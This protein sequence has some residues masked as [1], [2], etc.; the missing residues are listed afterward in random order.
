MSVAHTMPKNHIIVRTINIVHASKFDVY[1]ECVMCS[2]E[3]SY[4]PEEDDV[5][6]KCGCVHTIIKRKRIKAAIL[7][8]WAEEELQPSTQRGYHNTNT[9]SNITA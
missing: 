5:C 2:Y 6:P 4:K 3:Q 9:Y 7:Q 1:Y 8:R